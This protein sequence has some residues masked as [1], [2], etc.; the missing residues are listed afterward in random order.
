MHEQIFNN[1]DITFE[2]VA[3]CRKR[4]R[5]KCKVVGKLGIAGK[6]KKQT[7][8]ANKTGK[9]FTFTHLVRLSDF[10]IKRPEFKGVKVRN[11]ITLTA[12]IK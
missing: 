1:Q 10:G 2:G 11:E 9:Q 12:R 5:V 3:K 4:K 7:F 8:I 6:E